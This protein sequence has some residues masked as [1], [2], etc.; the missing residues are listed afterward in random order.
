MTQVHSWT[1]AG[2]ADSFPRHPHCAESWWTCEAIGLQKEDTL[3]HTDQYTCSSHH[4]LQHKLI[5][6]RTLLDRSFHIV[7]EVEDREQEEHHIHTGLQG[8]VTQTGTSIRWKARCWH[9]TQRRLPGNESDSSQMNLSP[10]WLSY[11]CR[12]LSRV[13]TNATLFLQPWDHSSRYVV[14]WCIQK[15]GTDH[16]ISVN[17]SRTYRARIATRLT[18]VRQAEH[19]EYDFRNIDKKSLNVMS[20]HTHETLADH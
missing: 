6:V 5:V 12:I 7:C 15:R 17:V 3:S 13:Y 2:R 19:L 1:R 20:G 10:Q 9:L 16:K 14:C 8:V 18:L 4:P 11:M